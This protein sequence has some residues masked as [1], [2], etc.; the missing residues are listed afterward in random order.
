[1]YRVFHPSTA[2]YTIFTVAH[3]NFSEIDHMLG[4]KAILNK[5][6]TIQITPCILSDHNTIKL[7]CNNKRSSR[8]YANNWSLNKHFSTIS[9]SQKK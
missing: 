3:G 1:V 5:Y 6:K 2:Q 9:G 4:Q 7:E 8:K